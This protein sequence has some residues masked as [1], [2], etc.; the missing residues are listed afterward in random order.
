MKKVFTPEKVRELADLIGENHAPFANLEYMQDTIA[1]W[2]E[3]NPIEPVVV[4]LSDIQCRLLGYHLAENEGIEDFDGMDY[5]CE[6][7]DFLKTQTFAQPEVKE[8]VV[9]LSDEQLID[10]LDDDEAGNWSTPSGFIAAYR[11]WAKTQTFAQ[12]KQ[13]EPDW[14]D[15]PAWANYLAQDA[16]GGWG[17]YSVKPF[18]NSHGVLA[19]RCNAQHYAPCDLVTPTIQKRPKP[20]PQV[21]VGQVWSGTASFFEVTI[22]GINST[23]LVYQDNKSKNFSSHEILDFV[24]KFERVS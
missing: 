12:S 16:N 10:F 21:E 9:G 20:A 11:K 13:F 8:V 6:I 14:D 1:E 4:G 18:I 2:L 15:A 17:F 5:E 19:N 24:T 3:Q 7:S 22:I 23:L